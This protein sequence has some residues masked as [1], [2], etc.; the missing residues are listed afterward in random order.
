MKYISLLALLAIFASGFSQER[1]SLFYYTLEGVTITSTRNKK[2][3]EKTPEIMQV[4]TSREIG[5]MNAGSTGEIL[6]YLTGVNVES[7]TGSGFPQ[8][9]V[10]SLDGFPAKYSLVMVDGIRLLTE[11]IHSGQNIDMI[12]PENIERIEIIKGTASSQYGSDAMGGIINI[13]TKKPSDRTES[14]LNLTGASYETYNTTLSVRTPVNEKLSVSIS[15]N[16]RQSAGVPLIDPSHRIGNMGYTKF[17]SMNTID[18]QFSDRSSLRAN[19]FYVQNSME[20]RNDD[21]YGKMF[22]PSLDF[23]HAFNEKLDVVTRLKYTH[24]EAEQSN[25]KNRLLNPEVFFGWDVASDHKLTMGGEYRHMNFTRSAVSEHDQHAFGLFLQDEIELDRLSLLAALRYDRV[26]QI[27]PVISP[28]V[29]VM[30]RVFD[31]MRIRA[32]LGR[33]FHA[34]TVQE[35]YEKGYGHGGRAYRFGNP[36]LQPEYSMTTT[37]S[38]EYAPVRNLQLFAYGYYNTIRNM[39]TP[40]YKGV[41]EENPDTSTVIDKW[42][43]TNIHEAEIYGFEVAFRYRMGS[44]LVI[45]SGYNHI[46]NKNKSTGGQLPYYPGWSFYS[47][48]TGHYNLWP[49]HRSSFFVSFKATMDRSVWN[50]KPADPADYD[51]QEGL[52]TALKDY[53]LLNAGVNLGISRHLDLNLGVDNI[54]GQDIERLDDLLTI[55]D[56]E[57]V[58]RIGCLIRF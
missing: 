15:E 42:V 4:I 9:S 17:T 50:W 22:M 23:R 45:E 36:D 35:L 37:A 13:I 49:E 51:N 52:T 29:S 47:K 8:R 34:P 16:Y 1:D 2:L 46:E 12:P 31:R 25:E 54:L 56:G 48:L 24:W 40:V 39:I 14:S 57:P 33:G 20:F 11:H 19:M 58:C 26:E 55:I 43:R 41:W 10:I 18:W 30:Y 32:S 44:H 3:L 6:E 28:K 38:I 21:V 27:D 5:T 7:G 53:Q